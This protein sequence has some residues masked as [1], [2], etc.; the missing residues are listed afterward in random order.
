MK[1]KMKKV[2]KNSSISPLEHIAIKQTSN[3]GKIV[4]RYNISKAYL[5]SYFIPS[6]KMHSFE[7]ARSKQDLNAYSKYGISIKNLVI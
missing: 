5:E 4:Q 2:I 7:L 1:P 3:Q 6:M